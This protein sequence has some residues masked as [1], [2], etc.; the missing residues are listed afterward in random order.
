M[1]TLLLFISAALT[2]ILLLSVV[3]CASCFRRKR[4]ADRRMGDQ[5]EV[6]HA[7]DVSPTT[8]QNHIVLQ[9]Q[10]VAHPH[11]ANVHGH[12]HPIH[13]HAG[14]LPG[15]NVGEHRREFVNPW[16]PASSR[17][18]TLSSSSASVLCADCRRRTNTMLEE[19]RISPHQLLHAPTS[20]AQTSQDLV[21]R[22][23][24]P[25]TS[26]LGC[27]VAPPPTSAPTLPVTTMPLPM[28]NPSSMS[29]PVSASGEPAPPEKQECRRP[30]D[31]RRR[32]ESE[33]KRLK[34][35]LSRTA[36][37]KPGSRKRPG[38]RHT[39]VEYQ[40]ARLMRTMLEQ[41]C[42]DEKW[43]PELPDTDDRREADWRKRRHWRR[44]SVGVCRG[45]ST[46]ELSSSSSSL[47]DSASP[48]GMLT[49]ESPAGHC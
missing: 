33:R 19:S 40:L 45:I 35:V 21:D 18:L 38:S 16:S 36:H 43:R 28:L 4:R 39:T 13:A 2:S 42:N 26:P 7:D 5:L 15:R 24:V 22:A 41:S 48:P 6:A 12:G 37:E 23:A 44:H 3:T 46:P 49:S 17:D 14:P 31:K 9:P 34:K 25:A 8:V 20:P 30:H 1:E 47:S 11:G 29:V 32:G 10:E 27:G